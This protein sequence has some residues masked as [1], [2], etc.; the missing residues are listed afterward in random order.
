MGATSNESKQR[1]NASRYTQ[2]KVSIEPELAKAFKA[3]C[4]AKG[5]SVAS[6][7]SRFMSSETGG[8]RFPKPRPPDPYATRQK[9]RRALKALVDQLEAIMDAEQRYL[10]AIPDNLQGSR[11]YDEAE[12]A[13]SAFEEAM[14]SLAEAY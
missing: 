6:E 14:T 3:R 1:W 9:R 2:V 13:V 8:G 11:H 5:V 10:D 12:Q 7:I 4:A